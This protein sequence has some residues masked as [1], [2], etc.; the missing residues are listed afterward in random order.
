MSS[1]G[2]AERPGTA[3][4]FGPLAESYDRLRPPDEN[5]QELFDLVVREGDL[6]G[7]RVLDV[8]CGTGQVARVL[9]ALGARVWGIDPSAE[10]LA[11]ARLAAPRAAFKKA[12]GEALPFKDGWFERA[13]F[14]LVLHLLDR[15]RALS[16]ARRVLVPGGRIAAATFAPEHFDRYWLN[17]LFPAVLE[18]DRGRFPTPA[19]LTR[20]LEEARFGGIRMRALR[21]HGQ[22]TREEALERIR[23][24]FISTLRLLDE[25]DFAA[26][27]ERAE[28]ELPPEL[29][30]TT[31]WVVVTADCA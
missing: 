8:G 28:C 29:E 27:L 23:G 17:E 9:T 13:V 19:D 15:P 4:D 24:R 3:P 1:S 18:I 11:R 22:I 12:R 30:F 21:Q 10:M 6:A 5:W 16:E 31:D 2:A 14:R 20:E 7:R 25:D 26:G